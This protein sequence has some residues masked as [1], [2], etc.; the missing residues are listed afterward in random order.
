MNETP[1]ICGLCGDGP[2][3]NDPWTV[4]HVL[5]VALGGKNGR[6]NLQRAH[7]LCNLE[8]GARLHLLLCLK[9]R[10]DNGWPPIKFNEAEI[11]LFLEQRDVA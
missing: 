11:I 1:E 6:Y 10:R 8:H 4:D 9:E 7:R 5:P 2:H 3:E